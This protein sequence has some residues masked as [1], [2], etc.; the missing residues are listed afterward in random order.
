[1]RRKNPQAPLA[2]R[3][4]S[5]GGGR[6]RLTE[7]DPDLSAALE[8]L[9]DPTTRGDP[10]SPLRWTCKSTQELAQ[11]LTQQGHELSPRTVGR[12]LNAAGYSLQGNRTIVRCLRVHSQ[13]PPDARS[14]T[15]RD[16]E[17]DLEAIATGQRSATRSQFIRSNC[18]AFAE[19]ACKE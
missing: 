11:A 14:H 1:M 7:S 10:M 4:R 13:A 12:L 16:L 15:R 19:F 5:P 17:G 9:I 18:N 3:L 8:W 6:K 2:L